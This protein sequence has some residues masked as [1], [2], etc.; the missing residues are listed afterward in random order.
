MATNYRVWLE[1]RPRGAIGA[2]SAM[3]FDVTAHATSVTASEIAVDEAHTLGLET[4]FPL[5]VITRPNYMERG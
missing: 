5:R 3:P 4:R 2:F 1:V